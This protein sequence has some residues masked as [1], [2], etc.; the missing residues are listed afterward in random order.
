MSDITI[1]KAQDVIWE[2]YKKL[3]LEAL[4]KE[5]QAFG[6]SYED[7]KNF[8]DSEWQDRLEQYKKADGNWMI[9]ASEGNH[10]VGML[11]AFQTK[12]DRKNKAAQVIGVYVNEAFRGKGISRM[13]MVALLNQLEND[14]VQKAYLCVNV[15]QESAVKLYEKVGFTITGKEKRKLGDGNYYDEYDMEKI[16]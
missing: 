1:L 10:L 3:R 11:G 9:F 12:E 16:L 2:D 7:Q 13:L 6:S 4:Q 5:P 8:S 14:G 15:Q